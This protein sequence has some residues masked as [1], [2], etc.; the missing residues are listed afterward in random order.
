MTI[1]VNELDGAGGGRRQRAFV[2]H[3]DIRGGESTR[4]AESALA[5]GLGLGLALP[6]IEVV[7]G[8]VVRLPRAHPG[9]LFGKGKVAE[10][11][12]QFEAAEIELV[13]IDG[14]VSPVQQRNL[15]KE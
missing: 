9:M 11:K 12:A 15:E 14:P 2:V 6:G 1:D 3:P 7:G 8:Q 13:L 10:L 5:E 4:S